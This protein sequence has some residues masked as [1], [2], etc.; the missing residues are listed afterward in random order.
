MNFLSKEIEFKR[1]NILCHATVQQGVLC[2]LSWG[3]SSHFDSDRIQL[4][5]ASGYSTLRGVI[6]CICGQV[7]ERGDSLG[8][9]RQRHRV[10][11]PGQQAGGHPVRGDSRHGIN[12][13]AVQ[14]LRILGRG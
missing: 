8:P 11:H 14:T 9:E 2:M 13:S 4:L 5:D 3:Q 1:K 10:R 7:L 12:L 6:F